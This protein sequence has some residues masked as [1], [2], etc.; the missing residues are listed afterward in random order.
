MRKT[1]VL[2]VI[3][4]LLLA[5]STAGAA[6]MDAGGT[7]FSDRAFLSAM[8]AHHQDAV[9][10]SAEELKKGSDD[11]AKTWA[12]NISE[13]QAKE[14]KMMQ[15]MVSSMGGLDKAAFTSM[16]RMEKYSL[17]AK[18]ADKTFVF[19]MLRLHK[20]ALDMAVNALTLSSDPKVLDLAK[21]IIEKQS[22][23]MRG[24]KEWLAPKSR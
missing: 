24:F 16:R 5:A 19:G 10:M 4:L 18:D 17:P 3:S 12:T 15:E 6:P 7:A 20:S 14:M 8:I 9:D 22:A 23:E 2:S 1:L 11:Q 13:A 21:S